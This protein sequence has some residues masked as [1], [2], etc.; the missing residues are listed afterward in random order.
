MAERTVGL[1]LQLD[2]V[3][4]TI[5][6]VE[7]LESV[8]VSAKG[9]LDALDGNKFT[10]TADKAKNV[11][12]E[13]KKTEKGVEDLG[14]KV[15]GISFEKKMESFAKIV[16][17]VSAGFAGATAAAQLFGFNSENVTKAATTAQELLTVAM[18][19]RGFMEATVASETV[20][21][22]VATVGSTV[23]TEASTVATFSLTAAL[24]TLYATM[25]ANPFT[26]ILVVVG[27]LVTAFIALSDSSEKAKKAQ[28]ALDLQLKNSLATMDDLL[29]RRQ[30]MNKIQIAQAEAEVTTEA[31]KQKKLNEL[32]LKGLMD[33]R[34]TYAKE[35]ALIEDNKQ[36]EIQVLNARGLNQEKYQEELI[37]IN[38]KY[39]SQRQTAI[40]NKNNAENAIEL[41]NINYKK[42]V[43]ERALAA[44]LENE[45]RRTALIKGELTRRL[46][47]LKNSYNEERKAAIKNGEDVSLVERLYYKNR[48]E[49]I[50]AF[51]D[52]Y[53]ESANDIYTQLNNLT[54]GSYFLE[55]SNLT[56]TQ[57]EQRKILL[58]SQSEIIKAQN[59]KTDAVI[60]LETKEGLKLIET[61][62]Q[63]RE[64]LLAQERLFQ[65]QLQD[66]KIR[67][68]IDGL[69]SLNDALIK[70]NTDTAE[71][72]K[73]IYDKEFKLFTDNEKRKIRAAEEARFL[74]QVG[75][76]KSSE[77][78]DEE[79]K[80]FENYYTNLIAGYEL[81]AKQIS[82][83]A[84]IKID[85]DILMKNSSRELLLTEAQLQQNYYTGVKSL[86][87]LYK[88][89]GT[90]TREEKLKDEKELAQL[91]IQLEL[92][93]QQKKLA[94]Q[95]EAAKK[96]NEIIQKDP[97]QSPEAKAK[98]KA[99][100]L[101][102]EVDYANSVNAITKN[103]ADTSEKT[104][105]ELLNNIG[106]AIDILGSTLSKISSLVAQSYG[107]QLDR[108]EKDYK[109]TMDSVVGDTQQAEE[110]RIELEK[111]Y[112]I[113]RAEIEKEARIKS[114]QFQIAQAIADTAS[115]T[116]KTFAEYGFTPVGFVLAGLGAA[117]LTAQIAILSQQLGAEQSMARGGL[118]NGPS[119]EQGG[120]RYAN[121]GVT[122]EGNE[123]V[124][125][126]RSTLQY[127]S[128]L[129]QINQQGGGKPIYV[130]SAM[131]SRLIEVLASQKQT[132]VRAYVLETDITKS[133]AINRRL[134]ALASF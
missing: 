132:P 3:T 20:V 86:M 68:Q 62:K 103:T 16:G 57:L 43:D 83:N 81:L 106:K 70:G 69:K 134:E 115:A 36:R 54:T 128:L 26:A 74:E 126:R 29:R 89:D 78:T 50:K 31:A 90:K 21:Q 76:T 96:S 12:D 37:K 52:Q 4:Q 114:L 63:N 102:L 25:L 121:G 27:L 120:V 71:L 7:E 66:L 5:S 124:I 35:Y 73:Q 9:K 1:K 110:K 42:G 84:K 131:D 109:K 112:N 28:E 88:D 80:T 130:N 129:S 55:E 117:L 34:D 122:L 108:L 92:D 113:K 23:A 82:T 98:A 91:L 39:D 116:I 118:V 47:E 51:N 30:D 127:G 77:L 56:R 48:R 32:R 24:R 17:G 111:E 49:A 87:D 123:A 11:T 14:K 13:V 61:T 104:T 33:L 45:K 85:N 18:A 101:K 107:F 41:E 72:Q 40:V 10:E 93:Y 79:I 105:E 95:L 38:Q 99:D 8:L 19:A 100:L 6:S 44:S 133:Q 60:S 53:I 97:N 58:E 65:A 64:L 94:I 2:G 15:Q 75:K 46:V 67:T 59:L 119:H 22:T 125:N